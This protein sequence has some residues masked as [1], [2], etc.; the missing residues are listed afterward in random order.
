MNIDAKPDTTPTGAKLHWMS[1]WKFPCRSL[2]LHHFLFQHIFP[3]LHTFLCPHLPA[4]TNLLSESCRERLLQERGLRSCHH[5]PHTRVLFPEH[6]KVQ[7]PL[8]VCSSNDLH[9]RYAI[10][11]LVNAVNLQ[12]VALSTNHMSPVHSILRGSLLKK[13]CTGPQVRRRR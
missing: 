2:G 7:R 12:T 3:L 8:S 13:F 4:D 9:T 10:F 6:G 11:F 5:S 1:I